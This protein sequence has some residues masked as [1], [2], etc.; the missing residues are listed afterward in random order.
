MH[1][2]KELELKSVAAAIKDYQYRATLSD[3]GLVKEFADLGSTKT[4]KRIL[5]GDFS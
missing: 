1:T 5:E 4:Y 2:T 3:A